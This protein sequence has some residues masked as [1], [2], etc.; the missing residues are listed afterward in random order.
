MKDLSR[1]IVR[2]LITE[3]GADLRE[4]SNQYAFAVAR[5]ANK[6]EIKR[7]VEH[8]FGV[9]VRQVRTMNYK[10]KPKRLGRFTGTRAG[11]KKAIVTLAAEDKIDL[12]DQV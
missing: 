6:L 9:S 1:V 8:F 12:F 3:K 11:W 7:A 10:G 5:E 4:Q 2:P